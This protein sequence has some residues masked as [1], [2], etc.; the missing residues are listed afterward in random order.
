[1][2]ET[3][4]TDRPTSVELIDAVQKLLEAE[5]IPAV[6]DARLRF[7]VLVAANVLAIV[8]R[9]LASEETDLRLEWDK[10]AGL[11]QTGPSPPTLVADWRVAVKGLNGQL[12]Q[13]IRAGDYDE[14]DRFAELLRQLRPLV[15][16]K[17]EIANPRFL[18]GY[19]QVW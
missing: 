10:L 1:M 3:T 11:L 9:E 14:P 8:S 5:V 4:M 12:C 13:C 6:A 17:L 15:V 16:R 2:G 18:A 7:Q 19:E